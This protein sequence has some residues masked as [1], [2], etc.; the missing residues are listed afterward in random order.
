MVLI[1]GGMF[2]LL[3]LA[4]NSDY[5]I[6]FFGIYATAMAVYIGAFYNVFCRASKYTLFDPAKERVYIPLDDDLKT[7]GKAA[8]ETIG[9]R[10]GKGSGAFTQQILL[11]LFPSL[12]LLDLSPIIFGVFL[13]VVI[14][15]FYSTTALDRLLRK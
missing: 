13:I 12:T 15:W 7:K 1:T 10:F 9:M 3:M 5:F 4:R 8:A 14:G 2:F 11:T 6:N